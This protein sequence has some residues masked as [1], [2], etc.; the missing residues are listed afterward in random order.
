L[1]LSSCAELASGKPNISAKGLSLR[2]KKGEGWSAKL[3][4]LSKK[5]KTKKNPLMKQAAGFLV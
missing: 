4:W 2:V 5:K 1:G 3:A